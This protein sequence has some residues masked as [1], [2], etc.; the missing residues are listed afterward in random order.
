MIELFPSDELGI[1][2]LAWT[3]VHDVALRGGRKRLRLVGGGTIT[4]HPFACVGKGDVVRQTA[5]GE[6]WVRTGDQSVPAVPAFREEYRLDV[7]VGESLTLVARELTTTEDMDLYDALS[8]FHY[9]NEKGF[10]RRS[11]LLL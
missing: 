8:Q 5:S 1:P 3:E 7:A 11:I 4:L 9:R 2:V 6:V 10:G